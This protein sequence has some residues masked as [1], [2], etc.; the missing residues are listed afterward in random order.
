M[1]LQVIQWSFYF[2]SSS[3]SDFYFEYPSVPNNNIMQEIY[4]LLGG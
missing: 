2:Y 3:L 4:L 1:M